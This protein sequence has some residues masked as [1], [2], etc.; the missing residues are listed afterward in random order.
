MYN[1]F[2]LY[3][4]VV[5]LWG[6]QVPCKFPLLFIVLCSYNYKSVFLLNFAC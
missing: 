2:R 4:G 5:P 1:D 3:K 6:R